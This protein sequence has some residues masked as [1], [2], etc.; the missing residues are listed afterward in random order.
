ML[1]ST[2]ADMTG[3]DRENRPNAIVTMRGASMNTVQ[4]DLLAAH[5]RVSSDSYKHF[6]NFL[7]K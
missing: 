4:Q 5:S 6:K 1:L 2:K 7:E 3:T